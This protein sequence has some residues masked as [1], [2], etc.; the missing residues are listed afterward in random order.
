MAD[1][2]H[3][4][5]IATERATYLRCIWLG[6]EAEALWHEQR[7]DALLRCDGHHEADVRHV[8]DDLARWTP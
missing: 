1:D 6:K 2:D 3:A 5:E 8:V 7:I 4:A